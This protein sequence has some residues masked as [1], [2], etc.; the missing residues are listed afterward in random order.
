MALVA[1][2]RAD[3]EFLALT[4][5]DMLRDNGIGAMIKKDIIAGF[6][7]DIGSTGGIWGEVLVEEEEF[8]KALELIGAFQ[9]TLGELAEAEPLPEDAE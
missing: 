7:F 1:V 4:I 5:R 2:Y 3:Q 6:N 8:N 9:G